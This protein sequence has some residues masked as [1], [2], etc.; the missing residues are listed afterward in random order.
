MNFRSLFAHMDW[1]DW[2]LSAGF[3]FALTAVGYLLQNQYGWIIGIAIAMMLL[4]LAKSRRD[5]A[6]ET[7]SQDEPPAK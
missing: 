6:R 4:W 5:E 7:H 3:I 1:L 2:V